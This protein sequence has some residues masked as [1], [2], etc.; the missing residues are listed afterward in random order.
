MYH[1]PIGIDGQRRGDGV[2][3]DGNGNADAGFGCWLR[4]YAKGAPEPCLEMIGRLPL[5]HE[6][7]HTLR[8]VGLP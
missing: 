5:L 4:R 7:Q 2:G 8:V 6:L 1:S 3:G